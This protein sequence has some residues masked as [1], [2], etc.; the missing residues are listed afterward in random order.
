[1]KKVIVS[2]V[3]FCSIC[4]SVVAQFNTINRQ[5]KEKKVVEFVETKTEEKEENKGFW[6]IFSSDS[7]EKELK[8]EIEEL[9]K[10]IQEK[11]D[12]NKSKIDFKR[13]EDSLIVNIAKKL[14]VEK[15]IEKK[16]PIKKEVQTIEEV[17]FPIAM[18]L[19]GDLHITSHFGMRNHPF[20][21]MMRMHNGIDL[22]A[23]Y[24]EVYSVLDGV[25]TA[26]GWD[27]KGGGV[28]LKIKH[29][30]GLETS[31]LHLSEYYYKTGEFVKAGTP[32]GKS[33]NTGN[34]TAPHLHFAVKENNRYI[35]PVPFLNTLL[36]FNG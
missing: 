26:S 7:K 11:E 28:F 19:D 15:T 3:F 16:R 34:S 29:S 32:I 25:V 9:K 24:Q 35:N 27:N 13:I 31:Y 20:T 21:K 33:G 30:H 12:T 8:K 17:V 1:M 6:K 4:F 18:P 14:L 36:N 22:R 5:S 10:I 2:S 23:N